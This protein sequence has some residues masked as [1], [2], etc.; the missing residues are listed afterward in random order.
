MEWLSRT[1]V[2]LLAVAGYVAVMTLVRLMRRRHDEVVADVK[3][4]VA[5]HRKRGRRRPHATDE[6]NRGAA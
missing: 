3:R 4:Q 6:Q 5:A 2:V 1:D